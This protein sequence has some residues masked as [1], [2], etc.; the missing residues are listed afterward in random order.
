MDNETLIKYA[1]LLISM[2]TDYL[3]GKIDSKTYKMNIDVIN[4]AVNEKVKTDK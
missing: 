4:N 3:L 1:E 2:S